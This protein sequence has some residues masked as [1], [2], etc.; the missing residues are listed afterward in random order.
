M[1]V[2]KNFLVALALGIVACALGGCSFIKKP[3]TSEATLLDRAEMATGV[4]NR[5]YQSCL[6]QCE[7]RSTPCTIRSEAKTATSIAATSPPLW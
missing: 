5:T 3:M 7:A 1:E 6:I 2:S 4:E